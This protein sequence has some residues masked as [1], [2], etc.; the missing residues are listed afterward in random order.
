MITSIILHSPPLHTQPPFDPIGPPRYYDGPPLPEYPAS[1]SRSE[2]RPSTDVSNK[3][4]NMIFIFCD[5]NIIGYRIVSLQYSI[6]NP[7]KIQRF[8]WKVGK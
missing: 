4:F 1:R 5:L 3:V 2:K 6:E 7:L 8:L